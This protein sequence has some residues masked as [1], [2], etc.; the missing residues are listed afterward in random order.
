[1]PFHQEAALEAWSFPIPLTLF[2]ALATFLYARGWLRL[3]AVFPHFISVGQMAAFIGGLFS[4]WIAVGSPLAALDD[5]LLSAHMA[6]HLLLMAV[7]PAL[8]LLGAPALPLLHGLPKRFVQSV[9]G[10]LLRWSPLR[11]AGGAFTHPVFCWF[12]ATITIIGW[13]VPAIF[14][15]GLQSHRWHEIQHASFF[16]AGVLFWWPVIQPWPSVSRWP[17]WSVPIYLFLATLPCDALSAFLTFCDRVVYHSYL[18]AP[19][20]LQISALQDQEWAGVLMWVSVTFIYMVPAA[21]VTVRTLAPMRNQ[22]ALEP[23]FEATQVEVV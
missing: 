2:L 5:E 6:Q 22:P 9:L 4:A 8:I 19:R 11:R 20:P 7:A 17:R 23:S 16:A 13:H 14:E 10:P 1:M 18:L 3:R 12:A 15:F 21:M